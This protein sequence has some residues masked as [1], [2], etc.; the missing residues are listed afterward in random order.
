[1]EYAALLRTPLAHPFFDATPG[2]QETHVHTLGTGER[3]RQSQAFLERR[4]CDGA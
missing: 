2:D 4:R 3:I 1:M